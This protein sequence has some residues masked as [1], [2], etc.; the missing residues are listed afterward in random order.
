VIQRILRHSNVAVTQSCY[1]QTVSQHAK[2][3]MENSRLP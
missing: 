2:A 3:A 1:I